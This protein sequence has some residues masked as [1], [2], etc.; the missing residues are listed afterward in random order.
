MG[1]YMKNTEQVQLGTDAS[2]G[3]SDVALV[4]KHELEH[5]VGKELSRQLLHRWVKR[6]YLSAVRLP[7]TRRILG[8]TRASVMKL[9]GA[10][11]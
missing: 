7:D 8:Y 10:T 5:L 1:P 3:T 2:T 9:I 11:C 6:G 4:S